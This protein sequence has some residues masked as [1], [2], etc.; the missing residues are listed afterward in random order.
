M[1]LRDSRFRAG[2]RFGIGLVALGLALVAPAS[3]LARSWAYRS[4]VAG[5]SMSPM[6]VPG[7]WLL[8]D[9]DAYD[10]RPARPGDL[11]AVRDPREPDRWLVKR[12]A[13]IDEAGRLE[14][15]GDAPD[16]ST[17]SRTFGPVDADTVV[18]RPWARYWPPSRWGGIR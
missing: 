13:T 7:D 2:V 3:R 5:D 12:V 9:P 10:R 1:A 15:R 8:V 11:V 17:D 4:A 14:L 16:R 18:G 6:L